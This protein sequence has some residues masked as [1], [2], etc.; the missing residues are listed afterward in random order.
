MKEAEGKESNGIRKMMYAQ[1]HELMDEEIGSRRQR[2]HNA[3]MMRDSN[4]LW[5]LITACAES[6]FVKFF[7]LSGPD[8][9]R[10]KGMGASGDTDEANGSPT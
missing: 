5:D 3:R 8:A 6:A 4:T 2:L 9:V 10:M 1:L 7:N